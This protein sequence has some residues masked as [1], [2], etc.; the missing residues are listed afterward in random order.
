MAAILCNFSLS[1][2]VPNLSR[3]IISMKTTNASGRINAT[4]TEVSPASLSSLKTQLLSAVAG[5]DRGLIANEVDVMAVDTPA[6]ELE[7]S[8]SIVDFSTDLDKLQGRWRLVYSSAFASGSLGGL[9]P[10]PPTGRLPL[11]LGQ[12][13][14]RIDVVRREFDNIVNLQIGTL[15][16]L[17][18]IEVTATLAHK[19]EL[20][21]SA[22]IRIIFER[23]IVQPAGGLSQLPQV[24]LPELPEIFRPPSSLRSGEFKVTFLDDDLRIT[25]GDRGELRV[26]LKL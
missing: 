9:R 8:G 6:R 3:G 17:P 4:A 10:G 7:A 16:P 1:R 14:Q 24:Q 11:T 12:V 21:D 25:R 5:L 13:F 20:I 2:G 15:W 19:F 22:S 23:T 18:P 26:F